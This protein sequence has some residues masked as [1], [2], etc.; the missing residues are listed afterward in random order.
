MLEFDETVATKLNGTCEIIEAGAKTGD[1]Q[2][3]GITT[4]DGALLINVCWMTLT[5]MMFW[6]LETTLGAMMVGMKA[7]FDGENP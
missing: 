4:V 5:E 2:L 3:S 1:D 6:H 7:G